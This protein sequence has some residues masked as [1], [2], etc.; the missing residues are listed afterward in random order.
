[1][2]KE[3]RRF[4]NFGTPNFFF[5]LLSTIKGN[6][7]AN[8]TKTDINRL[9]YNRVIDDRSVFDGCLELALVIE[10]VF[11]EN[12]FLRLNSG[13]VDSLNSINQMKDKFIENLFT[14]LKG[15]DE[16][17][18]I[19]CSEYLSHDIIYKSLQINNRAFGLKYSS[20]KQLL[21]D[22]D[23][24]KTH[25]TTELNSFIINNRY[26]KLFDKTVLPE[27]KQRKIGI[28]EFRKVMEQQQIFGEEAEKFVLNYEFLRLKQKKEIIWVAEYIVNEGYDIVSYNHEADEFPNRFIEVKSY[29]GEIP[30]FF[31]SR[32]EY[33]VAK[34][35]K[36]EYWIYLV[37]RS[38]MNNA[39]YFPILI[40][41]PF[42]TIL[43]ND[44]MW[45]K[46]VEKYKIEL[47]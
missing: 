27:I 39:G 43:T 11:L 13:I 30:Y 41:N 7:G 22:F 36:N 28:D 4:R 9:F 26:K 1:M 3:L 21:I 31:W 17:H 8:Y 32:N 37:N 5:E 38:L 35:K 14:T 44:E 34:R 45:N 2:L 25:P 19:F 12:N 47:I 23:A 20:F 46:Q 33:T 29:D 10:L 40:Q 24:I 18:S 6:Q 16:F 15:D 42:D